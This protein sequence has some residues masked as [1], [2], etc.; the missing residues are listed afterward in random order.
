MKH[1]EC[2]YDDEGGFNITLETSDGSVLTTSR[3]YGEGTWN[4][5][6]GAMFGMLQAAGYVFD[7]EKREA[8]ENLIWWN[9]NYEDEDEEEE[10]EEDEEEDR[11][12]EDDMPPENERI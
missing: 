6:I 10:D 11:E 7:E 9:E 1:F 8:F 5:I 4:E 3:S 2:G 12:D